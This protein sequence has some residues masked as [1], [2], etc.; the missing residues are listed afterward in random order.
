MRHIYPGLKPR[1][2]SFHPFGMELRRTPAIPQVR[3]PAHDVHALPLWPRFDVAPTELP[4]FVDDA[5]IKISL[6]RS[7]RWGPT[8]AKRAEARPYR[9][10]I[11]PSLLVMSMR[12][13][14]RRGFGWFGRRARVG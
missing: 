12:R 10:L 8:I 1:A 6:V 5:A 4:Q 13:L 14:A 9:S 11:A 2:Q 3:K 7:V